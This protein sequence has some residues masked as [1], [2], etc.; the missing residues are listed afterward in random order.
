MKALASL[1][2]FVVCIV[3]AVNYW[4]EEEADPI[5][6]TPQTN[7]P[8][9]QTQQTL[10]IQDVLKENQK[11][12]ATIKGYKFTR[13][14]LEKRNGQVTSNTTENGEEQLNPQVAHFTNENNIE[15]YYDQQTAYRKVNGQ[16]QK[17]QNTDGKVLVSVSYTNNIKFLLQNIGTSST[18]PAGI[19]MTQNAAGDYEITIDY[20]IFKDPSIS[21]S[22]F[23]QQK[24]QVKNRK[25]QLTI[26]GKTLEPAKYVYQYETF[27]G[28]NVRSV[29]MD[30]SVYN[31]P[32]SIPFDVT[33]NGSP[34]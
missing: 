17:K 7:E 23:Q 28:Q 8:T 16:W 11:K 3:F 29:E 19:T 31:E 34:A 26:N 30:L 13:V 9:T 21:D 20:L 10:S 24:L 1:V 4:N 33:G 32:I 5:K 12:I 18:P 15:Y 27:D 14:L 25:T 22:E 2:I 6:P